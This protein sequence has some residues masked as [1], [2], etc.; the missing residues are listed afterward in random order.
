MKEIAL[1]QIESI[2]IGNAEDAAAATGLTVVLCEEG[3][4]CGVDVR[5]G[6]PASRETELLN[7]L[8]AA[9]KIHAVLLSGGSAFGLDAAGGVMQYLEQRGVGFDTG[10]AKVP[11]VCQSCIFDLGVGD[12]AVRPGREMAFAAC[13]NAEK[14]NFRQGNFGAGTGATVGKLLG[15]AYMMKA[16]LGAYAV[17][18]ENGL[19]VGAVVCVNALGD[20]YD[21]NGKVIAGLLNEDKTGFRST[22][23]LMYGAYDV[24]LPQH[25]NTT[26][27]AVLT[28]AQ[29]SKAEMNKIA[30]MAQNGVVRAISPIATTAD[31]D[32]IYA[33][34]AGRFAADLNVVGTL[35]ADVLQR[36]VYNAVWNAEGA[37]G[38]LCA[39]D[40]KK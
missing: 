10:I 28:N 33:M 24:S 25:T 38:L 7:P 3:A 6:G 20:V 23:Q 29:F 40:L 32:S 4:V 18:L 21:E 19:Q 36:A 39:K 27:G 34:S 14:G 9:E 16:G 1:T 22:K 35:A 26:I 8:A 15:N 11:L 13:E 30:A 12:K 5:G 37:Y 2:K 31:G 17:E